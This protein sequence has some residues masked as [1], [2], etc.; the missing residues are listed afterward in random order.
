MSLKKICVAVCC[1]VGLMA[2]LLLD[3]STAAQAAHVDQQTFTP[4]GGIAAPVVINYQ[5][6]LSDPVSGEPLADGSYM[7]TFRLYADAAATTSSWDETHTVTLRDGMFST[8]LG[9]TTPVQDEFSSGQA[10]WLGVQVGSDAET[11]PRQQIAFVPYAVYA[12]NAQTFAGRSAASF[13]DAAHTHSGSSIDDESITSADIANTQ[14]QIMFP[15][16]TLSFADPLVWEI[17]GIRW[18]NVLSGASLVIPR[19]TDWDGTSAV[20]ITIFLQARTNNPGNIQFFVRPRTYAP[21]DEFDDVTGTVSNIISVNND[22]NV[23]Q[24]LTIS[25][26]AERFGSKPWWYLV[27]QRNPSVTNAYPDNVNVLTMVVNYTAVR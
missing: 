10:R 2:I 19:P 20:S 21:G 25:I 17:D 9:S 27:L 22:Q 15:A 12:Q 4:Q 16:T 7:V 18:P 14:R 3:H 5:A 23:Y 26:P 8:L 6:R 11:T 24:E 13:A 1:V